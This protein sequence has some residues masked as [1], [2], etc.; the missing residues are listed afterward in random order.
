MEKEL[1]ISSPSDWY[2][3]NA[4]QLAKTTSGRNLI[5]KHIVIPELLRVRKLCHCTL[6]IWQI[7]YPAENWIDARFK[8]APKSTWN[9]AE[10]T[11]EFLLFVKTTLGVENT[12]DWYRVSN[13]QVCD[14]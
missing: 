10:K 8:L 2:A 12:Q 1:N 7:L 6:T 5:K 14:V 13:V 3:V 9:S 4:K 11:R